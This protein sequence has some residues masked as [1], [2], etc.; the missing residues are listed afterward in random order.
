MKDMK[1]TC[2]GV[3]PRTSPNGRAAIDGSVRQRLCRP[4]TPRNPD[5][6]AHPLRSTLPLP[7]YPGG[8]GRDRVVVV[9]ARGV[10]AGRPA[11]RLRLYRDVRCG[12]EMFA[13]SLREV[14]VAWGLSV[15]ELES[16]VASTGFIP[17]ALGVVPW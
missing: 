8:V 13:V 7:S 15:G 11:S 9:K 1:E 12:R 5:A 10:G 2:F 17:H 6:A 16:F 4:S 14:R 3:N